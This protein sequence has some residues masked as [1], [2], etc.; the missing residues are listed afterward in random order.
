[1]YK[2]LVVIPLYNHAKTLAVVVQGIQRYFNDILIIDDGST[3]GAQSVICEL[4]IPFINHAVNRGKGAAIKNAA[5]YAIENGFTHILTIDADNQH[6]AKDLFKIS[7]EARKNPEYIWIGKRDFNTANVP[8]SSK[9]GRRFS[10]FWAR[11]QTGVHIDDIQSGLRVYP[12]FIFDALTLLENRYSFEV[13]VIIKALWAGFEVREIDISVY[14][15]K[16]EDRVSHFRAL[17]DNAQ[18][19]LLNT[20]LTIRALLPIPHKTF[21]RTDDGQTL[22]KNPFKALKDEI[23]KRENPHRLAL[24][25]AWSVFWGSLALPGVRTICLLFGLG[26]FNLNRPIGLTMDKL[27]MPPFIPAVCVAVG[28]FIC[29]GYWLT[30]FNMQTLGYE[31]PQRILEWIIGS[32]VVAPCFALLV[33]TT[34]FVLSI[35][36]R[37]CMLFNDRSKE[38]KSL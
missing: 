29:N 34:I 11:V 31:A 24:S 38:A 23:K 20:R 6:Y 5:C 22:T 21:V 12:L 4:N 10:A 13:E 18:I 30:D 19:S 33:G 27:A 26:Y 14:Y 17:Y 3:D 16:K 1:M 35:A 8:N 37:H 36:L 9:F 15:P 2:P 28:F 32:L 25:A 7:E